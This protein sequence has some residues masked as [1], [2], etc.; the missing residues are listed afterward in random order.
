MARTDPTIAAAG[1]AVIDL[2][3]ADPA[4]VALVAS[5]EIERQVAAGDLIRREALAIQALEFVP[6]GLT[7]TLRGLLQRVVDAK[8]APDRKLV[9]EITAALNGAA[10]PA[11][12]S[13]PAPPPAAEP[14]SPPPSEPQAREPRRRPEQMPTDAGKCVECDVDVDV[15]QVQLSWARFRKILCREHHVAQKPSKAA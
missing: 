13:R 15:E 1:Q 9:E 14:T 2:L 8:K 4:F 6:A 3:L 10:P 5:Q 11:P 12:A 7:A